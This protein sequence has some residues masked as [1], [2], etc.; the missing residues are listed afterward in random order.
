MVTSIATQ[1]RGQTTETEV[2]GGAQ[3]TKFDIQA[4]N[5]EANKHF[6]VGQ[7]FKNQYDNALSLL[8]IVQSGRRN[9]P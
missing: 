8:P 9:K 5:Y 4:N 2:S 1:Q 6:F 7:F 3:I